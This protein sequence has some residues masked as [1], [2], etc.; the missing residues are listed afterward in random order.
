MPVQ[1]VA[2]W[3][4]SDL[5][6]AGWPRVDFFEQRHLYGG[7]PMDLDLRTEFAAQPLGGVVQK[8]ADFGRE[9]PALGMHDV[10]G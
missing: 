7:G 10:N 5:W 4:D 6:R 9:V 3:T 1:A 2:I 8:Q